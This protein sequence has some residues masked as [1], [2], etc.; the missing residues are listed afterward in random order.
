MKN[1]VILLIAYLAI[2]CA[3]DNKPKKKDPVESFEITEQTDRYLKRFEVGSENYD[4]YSLLLPIENGTHIKKGDAL[5][6][7]SVA[8]ASMCMLEGFDSERVVL[9]DAVKG[10]QKN[11]TFIRHPESQAKLSIS[12]DQLTGFFYLAAIAKYTDCDPVVGDMPAI[13]A[14]LKQYGVS[15]DWEMATGKTDRSTTLWLDFHILKAI[16][17]MYDLE[18]SDFD[19]SRSIHYVEAS[20]IVAPQLAYMAYL[21]RSGEDKLACVDG[22]PVPV[23]GN[24]LLALT[25]AI[26]A[27]DSRVSKHP[28]YK[29][30]KTNEW[31]KNISEV[32]DEFGYRNWLFFSMYSYFTGKG[33][34]YKN[35]IDDFLVNW[36]PDQTGE[37]KDHAV[38]G[39]GCSEYIWQ[40][41]PPETCSGSPVYYTGIDFLHLYS[42]SRM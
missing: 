23:F 16:Y 41:V 21:C 34:G 12:K 15:H 14:S 37:E 25:I 13:L 42:W 18:N 39:W 4:Q 2:S 33:K 17:G 28:L 22:K 32:G 30:S 5:I 35:N 29:K 7:N 9:W 10:L 8:L 3:P 24:H 40:R 11:G 26:F 36:F 27:V 20:S 38:L 1:L 31:L 19:L 6:F